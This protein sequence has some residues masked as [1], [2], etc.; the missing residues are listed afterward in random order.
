MCD[1]PAVVAGLK[2]GFRADTTSLEKK[3]ECLDTDTMCHSLSDN[4]EHWL[5]FAQKW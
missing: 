1:R 4:F 5:R 2:T 3:N